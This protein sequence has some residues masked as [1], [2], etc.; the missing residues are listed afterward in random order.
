MHITEFEKLNYNYIIQE[1]ALKNEYGSLSKPTINELNIEEINKKIKLQ[2]LT[3]GDICQDI[4]TT[5]SIE[6]D[7]NC[8]EY[9]KFNKP[10]QSILGI[11]NNKNE[12]IDKINR[13]DGHY[14]KNSS[15]K[16]NEYEMSQTNVNI[17]NS[18]DCVNTSNNHGN[19]NKV[20]I[21]GEACES[22][23][24]LYDLNKE[25]DDIITYSENEEI[26]NN[27]FR[28]GQQKF[29][30]SPNYRTK[31]MNRLYHLLNS[32]TPLC[33]LNPSSIPNSENPQKYFK[34]LRFNDYNEK[35]ETIS[36]DES[37]LSYIN[38]YI[39]NYV[40]ISCKLLN[41]RIRLGKPIPLELEIINKGS[42]II[43]YLKVVVSAT[44]NSDIVESFSD[45]KIMFAYY[46]EP[47]KK[48]I[49]KFSLEPY[50]WNNEEDTF[51]DDL[52]NLNLNANINLGS[53]TLY[54]THN[55][56]NTKSN[57]ITNKNFSSYYY[58]SKLYTR[59]KNIRTKEKGKIL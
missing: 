54:S 35:N 39:E 25:D 29:I 12:Y 4:E 37:D 50:L 27:I 51:Y 30:S 19:N 32:V 5:C 42:N 55:L 16:K 10:F 53:N 23:E 52:K 48:C 2:P 49:K 28:R 57:I 22:N 38:P 18:I 13:L 33:K 20:C 17:N 7:Y 59:N 43:P 9:D 1:L 45:D 41:S 11:N 8:Q 15:S 56:S 6:N 34:L 14:I 3:K 26:D 44:T 46:L 36:T 58:Y 47:G 21:S 31:N 24:E 40:E